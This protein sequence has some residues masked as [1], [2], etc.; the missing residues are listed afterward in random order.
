MGKSFCIEK[1][2]NPMTKGEWAMRYAKAGWS[3]FPAQKG[4]EPHYDLLKRTGFKE[5]GSDCLWHAT[6]KQFFKAPASLRQV[7][8]WWN[9]EPN[10]DIKLCTGFVSKVTVLDIDQK[11][12]EHSDAGVLGLELAEALTM[13]AITGGGGRHV[14]F[15]Y[16]PVQTG[17]FSP[18]VEIKNDHATI[19]LSPSIHPDTEKAY[20]W[21]LLFPFTENNLKNLADYPPWI[22]MTST[23]S[24]SMGPQE[25]LEVFQGVQTGSRNETASKVIGKALRA[26][27]R[28]FKGAPEFIEFSWKMACY[29]NEQ[30][31]PPMSEKELQTIFKS[32]F[33]R[34]SYGKSTK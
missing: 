1:I 19:T 10:A 11:K 8:E 29:W 13:T 30:N 25:W 23:S 6:Y 20:T 32:I 27:Y 9:L 24:T 3:I 28:E 22:K 17:R 7:E 18:Q 31:D 2:G 16:Y 14:F 12:P 26:M 15:N 4:K 21:D 33:K 34:F 5:I